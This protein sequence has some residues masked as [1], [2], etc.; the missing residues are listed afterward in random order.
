MNKTIKTALIVILLI[1]VVA[2]GIFALTRPESSKDSSSNTK[3]EIPKVEADKSKLTQGNSLGNENAKVTLT[4]FGD[5]QCPACAQYSKFLK[6]E[7]LPKYGENVRL[8]FL[9]FPLPIHKN[10]EIAAQAAEAAGLQDKYWQM[11]ELLFEKQTEWEKDK[12][13][14]KKFEG[15]AKDIGLNVDQFKSDLNSQKVIDIVTQ[16]TALGNAFN[17]PGTP[18]FFVNGEFVETDNGV[19]SLI[20][21]IDKALAQ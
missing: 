16:H 6:Q 20:Q 18:A 2:F 13:P 10:A 5:F 14:S 3:K 4:E 9:N 21:A 19:N 1:G 12:N 15:Y 17:L 11:N 8:V 7:I